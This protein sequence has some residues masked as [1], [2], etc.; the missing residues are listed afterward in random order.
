[1][2]GGRALYAGSRVFQWLANFVGLPIDQLN[3]IISQSV[4]L[5]LAVLYRKVLR[6]QNVSVETRQIF[7]LS[8]GIALGYFCF[9]HQI[10]HLCVQGTLAYIVMNNVNPEILHRRVLFISMLYLSSLHL[11][12]LQY[13]FGGWTL[14]ITGPVMIATQ[15]V[16][17]I[18]FSLHD[19]LTRPEDKLTVHQRKHI[20]KRIPTMLEFFS[21]IF[22]FQTLLCGPLVFYNDYIDF[23]KGTNPQVSKN[24]EEV[25]IESPPPKQVVRKL[26]GSIFFGLFLI[27]V[28]PFFPVNYLKGEAV[29][30]ASGLG[31]N[32]F[33]TDG[34]PKWDL[35]SN[36]DILKFE[37]SLNVRDTVK[38][39]NKSTQQWLK[40]IV[41]DRA[42]THKTLLTFLLSALWHGFYPGYYFTF[43]GGA[44]FTMA[45]RSVRRSI[46]PYFQSS[47]Q[48]AFV[49]DIITCLSTKVGL[50]YIV[51]PFVIV[52]F[53]ASLQ[54]YWNFYFI[55]H[56][57]SIIAIFLLPKVFPPPEGQSKSAREEMDKLIPT[58][59]EI[60]RFFQSRK[61]LN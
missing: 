29:A 50:A 15:K 60:N 21:Y 7:T 10:S 37:L 8:C 38:T 55:G 61:A 34:K 30:N 4:M 41:Y 28:V 14:D 51:F 20:I 47:R 9:G 45:A 52:E 31:F 49:Y 13:E 12:R 33:T 18:A 16:T 57:L 56:I 53:Y 35:V 32:G 54:V 17:S 42:P 36:I 6:H 44:L 26:A 19:G 43:F 24:P 11:L 40:M 1:M 46:R 23:V 2:A 59:S 22:H 27:F 25:F 3:F 48:M 58:A 5:L 39:W